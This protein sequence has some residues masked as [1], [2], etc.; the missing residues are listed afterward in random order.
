[1]EKVQILVLCNNAEILPI[2]MRLID[3]NPDWQATGAADEEQGLS[4]FNQRPFD[5]V[6]LGSGMDQATEHRL[7][8]VCIA[9]NPEV[10]FVQHYGGGSGLL[11][12]EILGALG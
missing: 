4:L 12:A 6:L 2:V 7:T 9:I 3:T 1:M 8:P 5:L 11:K 10:K